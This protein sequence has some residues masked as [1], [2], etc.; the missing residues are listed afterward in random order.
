MFIQMV[1]PGGL[2]NWTVTHVD[3]SEGGWHPKSYGKEDIT[4]ETLR[5]LQASLY[6]SCISL[7]FLFLPCFCLLSLLPLAICNLE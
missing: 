2:S 5:H 4:V 7:I 1:D 3:W 6:F